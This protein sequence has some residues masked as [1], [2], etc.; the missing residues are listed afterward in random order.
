PGKPPAGSAPSVTVEG[1]P[2]EPATAGRSRT[3]RSAVYLL[4]RQEN[5]VACF[6]TCRIFTRQPRCDPDPA[7]SGQHPAVPGHLYTTAFV[8]VKPSQRRCVGPATRPLAR[9]LS[10]H[11]YFKC[12]AGTDARAIVRSP[13][14]DRP[15]PR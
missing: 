13:S 1:I 4:P 12:K 14:L 8:A 3:A 6:P 7:A 15:L 9:F 11:R 10:K 5:V 2:Q